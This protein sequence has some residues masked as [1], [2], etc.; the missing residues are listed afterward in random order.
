[1]S[2]GVRDFFA[3]KFSLKSNSSERD[4]LES[5]RVV[6]FG[7]Y[8][9]MDP[10]VANPQ[11]EA[12]A[13]RVISMP[14]QEIKWE[15]LYGLELAMLKL[16][17]AD[18]LRRVAWVLRNE[19]R[20][21]ATADEWSDYV[22]SN[23]PQAGPAAPAA[24]PGMEA[25]DLRADLIRLQEEIHWRYVVLWAMENFRTSVI[26]WSWV[27]GLGALVAFALI[28]LLGNHYM[29]NDFVAWKIVTMVAL[30]GVGGGLT[31]TLR[32][33]QQV[34]WSGNADTDI[35]KLGGN[36]SV[37]LSPLLG[38]IS[39]ILLLFLLAGKLLD[40]TFF[41][42]V[43]FGDSVHGCLSGIAGVDMAKLVVWSYIAGFAERFVPDNLARIAGEA[44]K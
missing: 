15:D 24:E 32:R 26:V 30:A 2:P 42:A 10:K 4:F 35:A 21:L 17:P 1:M 20:E 41:P 6:L 5:Y 28:G 27:G 23:P 14:K 43:N 39:A 13:R 9:S 22:A 7:Q 3:R 16:R 38:G 31:S 8:A 12:E 25:P 34:S 37:Y 18:E 11:A 36:L 33:I 29:P 40:G 44:S 19:Y